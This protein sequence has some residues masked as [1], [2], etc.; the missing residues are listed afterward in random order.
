MDQVSNTL[1]CIFA[2]LHRM[3]PPKLELSAMLFAGLV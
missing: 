2:D 1:G 3:W